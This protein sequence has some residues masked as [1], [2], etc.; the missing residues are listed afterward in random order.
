MS[1]ISYCAAAEWDLSG[2]QTASIGSFVFLGITIGN[3]LFGYIADQYGRRQ[4]Y[5]Y[6]SILLVGG[7]FLT[8]LAPNFKFLLILRI[9]VGIGIGSSPVTFDILAEFLPQSK[10]NEFLLMIEFFWTLGT[11]YVAGAAWLLLERHGWRVLVFV[12]TFPV[13][14]AL[15]FSV[16]LLPESPRWLLAKGKGNEAKEV[17]LYALRMNNIVVAPFSLKSVHPPQ[18]SSPTKIWELGHWYVLC[19][20]YYVW[21]G[22]GFAYYAYIL[23]LSRVFM[24]ENGTEENTHSGECSFEYGDLFFSASFE[25]IGL[26]LAIVL[27]RWGYSLIHM[28]SLFYIATAF[29]VLAMTTTVHSRLAPIFAA[30]GRMAI[31]AS[32]CITWIITPD[33]FDTKH[34]GLGHSVAVAI[35]RIGAFCAPYV[36]NGDN[37]SLNDVSVI[38]A[39]LLTSA[40]VV[41]LTLR[42]R[43]AGSR[44]DNKYESISGHG[45]S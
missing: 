2:A 40:G 36:V 43:K 13:L 11:L 8:G 41:A 23:L 7:G 22:L 3:L 6:G 32:S 25:V 33:C 27:L 12:S 45:I 37:F 44:I 38:L 16:Y 39:V 21:F 35:S 1:Y 14:V 30:C 31:M 15:S 17:I 20:L 42:E 10:R 4:A 9:L 29:C 19:P 28:Q 18:P 26:L 5:L 34:R 24:S